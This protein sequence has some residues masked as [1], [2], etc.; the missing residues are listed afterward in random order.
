M[1]KSISLILALFVLF[2]S[3]SAAV[4]KPTTSDDTTSAATAT[5]GQHGRIADCTGDCVAK[6]DQNRDAS[7][8]GHSAA[9]RNQTREGNREGGRA[10]KRNQNRTASCSQA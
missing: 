7:G 4:E 10:A 2:V 5:Q 1:K 9:K 6:R 3:V 8:T